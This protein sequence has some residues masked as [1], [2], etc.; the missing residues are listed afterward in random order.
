MFCGLWKNVF[1]FFFFKK[2]NFHSNYFTIIK[3]IAT[4]VG[5]YILLIDFELCFW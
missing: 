3:T 5:T 1:F 2:A 4:Y